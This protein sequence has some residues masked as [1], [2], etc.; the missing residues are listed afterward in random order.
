[1]C[2]NFYAGTSNTTRGYLPIYAGRRRHRESGFF[3]SA[4]K[5]LAPIGRSMFSGVKSLAGNKAFQ[6]IVKKALQKG[7]EVAANVTVDALQGRNVDE[8]IRDHSKQAALNAL[9]G[10]SKPRKLKQGKCKGST[11]ALHKCTNP[12]QR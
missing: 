2:N 3:S 5:F 1:M 10:P 8:S 9:V 11:A 7:V 6:N 12:I 4:R